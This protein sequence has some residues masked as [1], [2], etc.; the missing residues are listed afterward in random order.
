MFNTPEWC[1]ITCDTY[2]YPGKVF[3]SN[4]FKIYYSHIKNRI[5]E[6]F[7]A[8]S[9]GDFIFFDNNGIIALKKWLIACAPVPVSIKICSP[10]YSELP[11]LINTNSGYVHQIEYDSYLS[12]YNELLTQRFKRNIKKGIK[13]NLKIKIERTPEAVRKFWEMHALLRQR[14]F[15]EIPQP[16]EYF[17]NIYKIF[18]PSE[19]GFVFNA[20]TPTDKFIAGILVIIHE[21]TAYYKFNVSDLNQL[22]TRPNNL[23][24][25]RLIYY[26]DS[27]SIKKLN[28]GYT[29]DSSSYE[30]LRTY[31]LSTGAKEYDRFLLRTPNYTEL[32]RSLIKVINNDVRAL[33][34]SKPSLDEVDRFSMENYK[35]FI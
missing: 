32:D 11:G 2:G 3:K 34:D 4:G 12:W 18:F 8:P 14:K 31:K 35:Y 7:I 33:I 13:S 29:G 6:Y 5:G 16:W 26:L 10:F 28:L 23:L 20:Y 17:R 9:F 25:D 15:Q 1:Q 24:I 19:Q 21:G 27:I 30:G 22:E